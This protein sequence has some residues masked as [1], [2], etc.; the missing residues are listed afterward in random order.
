MT[1]FLSRCEHS[2]HGVASLVQVF[3][4]Y[5]VRFDSFYKQT[6]FN[7]KRQEIVQQT[8]I[9]KHLLHYINYVENGGSQGSCKKV[10]VT[11]FF[12]IVI[13]G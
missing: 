1:L 6:Q 10:A 12:A 8:Y 2:R 13:S 9:R 3:L 5:F 4:K 7:I 11:Q